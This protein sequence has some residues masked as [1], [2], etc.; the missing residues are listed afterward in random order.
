[1]KLFGNKIILINQQQQRPCLTRGPPVARKVKKVLDILTNS[2]IMDDMKDN[3]E[4][5]NEQLP[6]PPKEIWVAP[7]YD[8]MWGVS[9]YYLD[10]DG[11]DIRD[12]D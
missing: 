8:T 5:N 7:N 9:G 11:N 12:R 1:V 4:N 10:N 6:E 3:K 2:C